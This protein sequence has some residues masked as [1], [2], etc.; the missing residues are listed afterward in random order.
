MLVWVGLH[1]YRAAGGLPTEPV[2]LTIHPPEGVG[3]S[4]FAL[5]PDGRYLAFAPL[6][7]S[8]PM[9]WLHSLVTGET[10]PEPST[11][12]A[13]AAFWKPDSPEIAYFVGDQLKT[14]SLHGGHR[15]SSQ[16]LTRLR[17]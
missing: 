7:T 9:L 10:R 11:E 15:S 16:R 12:G 4:R 14:V 3:T 8:K 6:L 5:S 17:A 1:Y 13:R 2:Q